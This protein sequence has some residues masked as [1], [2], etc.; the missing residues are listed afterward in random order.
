MSGAITLPPKLDLRAA[1]PLRDEIL[2][3]AGQD[4]TLDAGAVTHL[5][6]LSLQVIRA[7]ARSWAMAGRSLT[8][9]NVSTD[10]ADQLA[11]LGFSADNVTRWEAQP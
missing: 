11:L 5:G 2:S 9:A 4:L 10:L 3:H 1:G 8:I 6:A 7:A